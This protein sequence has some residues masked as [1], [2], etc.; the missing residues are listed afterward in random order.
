VP[1]AKLTLKVRRQATADLDIIWDYGAVQW[2]PAKL[3][4]TFDPSNNDLNSSS[5]FL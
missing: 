2:S 3:T 4:D 5:F 1:Q